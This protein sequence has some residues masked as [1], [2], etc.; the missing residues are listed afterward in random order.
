M[1]KERAEGYDLRKDPDALAALLRSAKRRQD[2]S[3]VQ[4]AIDALQ[5]D[6]TS[7][8][9]ALVELFQDSGTRQCV[10]EYAVNEE[11]REAAGHVREIA[12]REDKP[13]GDVIY[14]GDFW[15]DFCFDIP[16][17]WFFVCW[18]WEHRAHTADELDHD[19]VVD[20]FCSKLETLLG[21]SPKEFLP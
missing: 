4:K 5:G 9:K 1:D 16:R 3:V 8:T 20:L 17:E 11:L 18:G 14:D 6:E 19:H 10:V 13:L 21:V 7:H 15:A 12:Y 2:W